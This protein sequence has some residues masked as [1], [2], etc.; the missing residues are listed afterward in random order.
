MPTSVL[1]GFLLLGLK[2]LNVLKID[3]NF[4]EILTYHCLGIGF[5]ALSLRV[6]K[7]MIILSPIL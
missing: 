6:S 2:Y 7:K 4:L 3:T 1:G 5:I